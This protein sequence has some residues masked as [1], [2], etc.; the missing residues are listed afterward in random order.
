MVKDAQSSKNI[1]P[2]KIV[3]AK[4]GMML[5]GRRR[6]T[7]TMYRAPLMPE[8]QRLIGKYGGI[9]NLPFNLT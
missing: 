6:K 7:G 5:C 9:E 4:D 1:E 3:K 8:A 2:G